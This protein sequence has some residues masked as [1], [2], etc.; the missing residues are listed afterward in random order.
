MEIKSEVYVCNVQLYSQCA[1]LET[2]KI[3]RISLFCGNDVFDDSTKTADHALKIS[4]LFIACY[5]T[6][7][8]REIRVAAT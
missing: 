1:E 6:K 8:A 4:S 7:T 5:P 2:Q 3:V